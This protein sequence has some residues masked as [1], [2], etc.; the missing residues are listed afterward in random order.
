MEE[1][2]RVKHALQ[3]LAKTDKLT[4]EALEQYLLD[5]AWPVVRRRAFQFLVFLLLLEFLI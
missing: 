4:P 3:A 5:Q 1:L 2:R